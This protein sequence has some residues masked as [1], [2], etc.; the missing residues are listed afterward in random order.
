[1]ELFFHRWGT[2]T[3][4]ESHELRTRRMVLLHGMGGTGAIWRPLGVSLENHFEIL[5]PDQRGHGRSLLDA[6]SG[7]RSAP[8]YTPLDYGQ[9][10]IETLEKNRFHPTWILGHSMGVR[11]ACAAAFL[12]LQRKQDWIQGLILID[13]G[14]SGVAGGGLGEGLARFIQILPPGFPD[15]AQARSFMESH[16]PDPAIAQYLMAVAQ[17]V[18]VGS[19]EITFPFDHSALIQTIESARDSSVRKWVEVLGEKGMPIRVLRGAKS[20]VWSHEEYEF[21][22]AHF[23]KYPSVEFLEVEDAGHGLPFE[24]RQWLSQMIED[25][26]K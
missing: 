23:Q 6:S 9:D 10:V 7:A 18:K 17:P 19:P 8:G 25:F 3:G 5:S 15:R 16:C 12:A 2:A 1:M 24:K 26:C 14:F 22:K 4:A 20:L 13:L 11:S 21:E